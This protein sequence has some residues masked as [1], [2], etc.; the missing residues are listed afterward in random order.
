MNR[1]WNRVNKVLRALLFTVWHHRELLGNRRFRHKHRGGRCF[2]LCN[3][4][5]VLRQDILPL[6]H[7]MVMSVSSGYLHRDFSRIKPAYHFVPPITYGMMTEEDVV[8]WFEEMDNKIG[9]AELFLSSTEYDLV[10]AH[11]LFSRR[12]VNYLCVGRPFWPRGTGILD[13]CGPIP[14]IAS[15]PIMALLVA[16]YMDFKEIY[17][18]GTDHD[19]L[20]TREY[21]YSFE[22]TVLRGKDFA[23]DEDGRI[24]VPI[25]EELTAYLMLWTQ[26]RHIKQIANAKGVNIRNASIGG[27]LDEFQRV[28]LADIF[29]QNR[30]SVDAVSR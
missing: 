13:I 14:P 7:E 12:S 22:P 27:M 4:P 16:L 28:Q 8:R 11:S 25:Y 24:R 10:K 29:S 9:E 17:L 30:S 19:S 3:G 26:Y 1:T 21:R 5:S 18:L 20:I 2:I 6:Q 15:A 23:V